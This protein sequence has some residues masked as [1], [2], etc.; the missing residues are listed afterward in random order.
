MAR[1]KRGMIA[2]KRRR[3]VLQ[4]TKG[5]RFG[6]KSKEKAAKVTLYHAGV[7]S[8]QARRKK[9]GVMR[10]LQQIK[11]NAS[12]RKLGLPFSKL[13]A[14]FKKKNI[15]LDRKV[16]AILAENHP[17]VFEKVVSYATQR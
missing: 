3:N 7:N 8:F 6:I 11:I 4:K 13:I 10:G 2:T 5:F 12:A 14:E 9:K 1:V 16:L 15:A 17:I